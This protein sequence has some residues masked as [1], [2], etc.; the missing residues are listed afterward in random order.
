MPAAHHLVLRMGTVCVGSLASHANH[1]LEGVVRNL[2]LDQMLAPMKRT[3]V[4]LSSS[5]RSRRT[6]AAAVPSNADAL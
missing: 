3:L 1:Q 4:C 2:T 6:D 5:D